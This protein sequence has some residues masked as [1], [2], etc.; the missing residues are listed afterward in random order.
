MRQ[1]NA[2]GVRNDL[3]QLLVNHEKVRNPISGNLPIDMSFFL[4]N[5]PHSPTNRINYTVPVGKKARVSGVA[6]NIARKVVATTA[7]NIWAYCLITPQGGSAVKIHDLSTIINTINDTI[8]SNVSCDYLLSVGDNISLVTSDVST[9]GDVSFTCS[10]SVE[11]F[12]E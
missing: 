11:E 7:A 10:A 5:A 6:L 4:S 9:G 8:H 2:S 3:L 1:S 12:D